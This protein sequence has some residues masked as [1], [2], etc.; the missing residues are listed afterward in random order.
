MVYE[1]SDL[2]LGVIPREYNERQMAKENL[3]NDSI[4]T[5][6]YHNRMGM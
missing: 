2:N 1:N 3:E 4:N 6:I 5:K